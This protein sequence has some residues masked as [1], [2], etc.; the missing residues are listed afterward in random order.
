MMNVIV[1]QY[2]KR[3]A[4][5]L[6]SPWERL[7]LHPYPAM[8]N[9]NKVIWVEVTLNT[10]LARKVDR[11]FDVMHWC[12]DE[13]SLY[14]GLWSPRVRSKVF[15]HQLSQPVFTRGPKHASTSRSRVWT[16]KRA[17]GKYVLAR[18]DTFPLRLSFSVLQFFFKT[19]TDYT[20][21]CSTLKTLTISK[22]V[23]SMEDA[24]HLGH[25]FY[26]DARTGLTEVPL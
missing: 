5:F 18:P 11:L 15:P 20:R 13:P 19:G 21:C 6:S 3:T 9:H 22:L 23:F 17:S 4:S 2:V 1:W 10:I 26:L 25:A 7:P 16:S 8:L 14:C 12:W 24:I